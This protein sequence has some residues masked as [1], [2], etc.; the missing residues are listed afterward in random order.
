MPTDPTVLECRESKPG[1]EVKNGSAPTDADGPGDHLKH[2]HE[3][4]GQMET[5][6][7]EVRRSRKMRERVDAYPDQAMLVRW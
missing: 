2:E 1:P 4:N 3:L 6:S 5:R 7:R